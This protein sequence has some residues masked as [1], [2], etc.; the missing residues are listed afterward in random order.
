MATASLP[1]LVGAQFY[2]V[3]SAVFVVM[4]ALGRLPAH[5]AIPA[6][7]GDIATGV[8][9]PVVAFMLA[10]GSSLGRPMA[11]GWCASGLP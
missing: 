2:R 5:F 6:G 7:W 10:R 4:L 3:I 9:A 1:T 11:L 8:L